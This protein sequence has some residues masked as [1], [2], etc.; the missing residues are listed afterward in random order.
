MAIAEMNP[1]FADELTDIVERLQRS[2]VQ[3]RSRRVGGGSGVIWQPDGL[4][5]TNAHVAREPRVDVELWDGRTLDGEVLLHDPRRDLA[6]V[7]VKAT[8][9]PAAPI[10]DSG[11]LRVGQ[12]V[13]AVGNPLG[14]VGALS[15]GIIHAIAPAEG[16]GPG[17]WVRA[18]VRLLPGNS[19]G[20]L[21]DASGR[22][23]GINSMVAGGLGLAVPSDAVQ[24]FLRD[25]GE[26][27][28]LGVVMQPALVPFKGQQV[29]GF[30]VLEVVAGSPAES[31]G[32]TMGDV[33]IGIGGHLFQDP[34]DLGTALADADP[35]S[36]FRL[37]LIRGGRPMTLE[38]VL[39]PPVET[40][41]GEAA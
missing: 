29:P 14:M 26:R 32:L 13:I 22:V 16:R 3:V 21:A 9:L 30:V 34:S 4:I 36:T 19:G 18:D 1:T 23:I 17:D 40:Q 5:I 7:K 20:P 41:A 33:L 15:T 11:A 24:R 27:P 10:G 38:V 37:E 35:G 31:A 12:L 39:A 6:A 2:T 25:R 8:D 28:Q